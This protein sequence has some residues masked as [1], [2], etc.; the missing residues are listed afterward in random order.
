MTVAELYYTKMCV[1]GL[2]VCVCVGV[3]VWEDVSTLIETNSAF[4]LIMLI[5]LYCTLGGRIVKLGDQLR[6]NSVDNQ[7]INR[8]LLERS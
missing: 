4:N 1:R 7:S 5:T 6:N 8:H 2:C 3:C